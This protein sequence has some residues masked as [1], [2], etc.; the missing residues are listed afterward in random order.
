MQARIV[1]FLVLHSQFNSEANCPSYLFKHYSF[2]Q[3]RMCPV[4]LTKKIVEQIQ[5]GEEFI[6][7]RGSSCRVSFVS[8]LTRVGQ[9]NS[10][11]SHQDPGT[12][13]EDKNKFI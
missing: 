10:E 8:D 1:N 4:S 12:W 6:T 7:S 2:N 13:S 9:L 11:A 3:L 5:E